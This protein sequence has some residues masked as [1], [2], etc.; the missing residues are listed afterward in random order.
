MTI[1]AAVPPRR[2]FRAPRCAL[3]CSMNPPERHCPSRRY[4]CNLPYD[5]TFS[6]SQLLHPSTFEEKADVYPS[7]TCMSPSHVLRFSYSPLQY[8]HRVARQFILGVYPIVSIVV[9]W[10]SAHTTL[11]I[12]PAA[13]TGIIYSHCL[14]R[15]R[16]N[17]PS[18]WMDVIQQF[19]ILSYLFWCAFSLMRNSTNDHSNQYEPLW[20]SMYSCSTYILYCLLRP[21]LS[22]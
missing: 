17:E 2:P 10:R 9:T 4:I 15:L 6:V 22:S 7:H 13:S 18:A 14:P 20:I 8:P 1:M 16:R 21:R 19:Y 5:T 3:L 11:N 12:Y